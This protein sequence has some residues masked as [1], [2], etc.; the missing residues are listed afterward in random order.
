MTG[1][2]SQYR[3]KRDFAKTPEPKGA[4]R[5]RAAHALRFVVQK[6]AARRLHYDFRVEMG[7]VLKSWAVPKGPSLDPGVKR[8]AVEVEDHPIEYG[9]FEG[10]I[11]EGEYGGGTVLVWDAGTWVPEGSDPEA[12]HRRGSLKFE[13]RGKRLRGRWGLVRM[14]RRS[15]GDKNWLL[16]K[17][18]DEFARPGSDD[19]VTEENQTSVVSGRDLDA[20]AKARDR[21]WHSNRTAHAE[22]D[23]PA[24]ATLELGGIEARASG[25][26]R[27]RWRHSWRRSS[28]RCRAAPSGC[29]RSSSMAIA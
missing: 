12:D 27:G 7:G 14:R 23:A 17:E 3:R 25:R 5:K 13:L 16:I 24:A 11:P 22:A 4:R 28:I 26:C 29:T 20:V 21:V 19:E 6:H 9:D 18:Q 15:G 8:L 10:V 2:L 1:G